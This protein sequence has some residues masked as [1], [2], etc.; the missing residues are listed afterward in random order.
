MILYGMPRSGNAY[1]VRLLLALLD[2][3][4]ESRDVDI[5]AGEAKT[6]AYLALNPRA[7]IPVLDDDGVVIWDSQAILV[8]LARAYG[9]ETWLPTAPA[10][11]ARVMQWLAFAGN[12]GL[13]GMARARAVVQFGR[14]WDVEDCN[15]LA[16]AGLAVLEGHLGQYQW[17]AGD[18]AT[19]ADIACFPYTALLPEADIPLDANP[20][21]RAWLQRVQALPGYV[22]MPGIE[23]FSGA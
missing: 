11:M 12:E 10:D 23:P 4:Y 21:V 6:P 22:A 18:H 19:I 5:F 16:H 8:Y 20:A 17:L 15:V 7:Q 13:F 1:K 3:A 2:I 14:P 9:G